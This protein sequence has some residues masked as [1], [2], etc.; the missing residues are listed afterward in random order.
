MG[1]IEELVTGLEFMVDE[2]PLLKEVEWPDSVNC[3]VEGGAAFVVVVGSGSIYK[4]Y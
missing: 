2:V 4:I 3:V 1:V